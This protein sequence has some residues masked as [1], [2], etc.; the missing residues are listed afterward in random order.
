MGSRRVARRIVTEAAGWILLIAGIFALILPGP[1]LLGVF[2]GLLILSHQYEWAERRVRPVEVMAMRS[3][4][5]GVKTWPR[6]L[7]S[8]AGAI[9]I[10]A[11]GI[12]WGLRPDAPGWWPLDDRWW[13]PGGWGTGATLLASSVLALAFIAYSYRR[14]HGVP[15]AEELAER[16]VPGGD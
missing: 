1:G 6:I 2:A 14:F 16:T 13:L 11:V 7:T 8:C 9:A 3:A 5:Q 15:D 10:G 4:A 12:V